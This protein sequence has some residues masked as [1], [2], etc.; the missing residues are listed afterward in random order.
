MLLTMHTF[1]EGG[2]QD[3]RCTRAQGALQNS[4][5]T[6]GNAFFALRDAYFS[7]SAEATAV[8]QQ[9][10]NQICQ[11]QSCKNVVSEYLDACVDMGT[12]SSNIAN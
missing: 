6:C 11:R 1:Q 12:V 5:A 7:R 2:T 3:N 9:N 4:A 8:I 10:L